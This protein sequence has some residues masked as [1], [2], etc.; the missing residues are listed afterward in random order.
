MQ[1]Y[2]TQVGKLSGT[3]LREVIKKAMQCYDKTIGKT[4]RRPYI[5]SKYFGKQKIFLGLFWEHLHGKLNHRDKLRRVKFFP[6]AIE[7]IQNIKYE[8]AAKENPH[9]S[10][11]ILYRFAGKTKNKET[12]FVQ[13]KENIQTREKFLISVFPEE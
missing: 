11:E 2:Q 6:A 13:I 1:Y 7:L 12:F 3:N 4:K 8:P 9:K 10:T 5:R